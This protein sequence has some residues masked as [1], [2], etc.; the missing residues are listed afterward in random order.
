MYMNLTVK[1]RENIK[2]MIEKI[3][4][5][6]QLVNASAIKAEDYPVECYDDLYDLYQLVTKQPQF[7]IN[8][9]EAIAAELGSLRNRK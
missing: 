3:V 8:E 9:M 7:S 5:K 1:N 2:Y 6:L 4:V